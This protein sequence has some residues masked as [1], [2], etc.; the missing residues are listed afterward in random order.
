MSVSGEGSRQGRLL[1]ATRTQGFRRLRW[2]CS[3]VF[4]S[5]IGTEVTCDFWC[6]R[7]IIWFP[8]SL[9]LFVAVHGRA[10][11]VQIFLPILGC[12]WSKLHWITASPVGF[13][14]SALR[15]VLLNQWSEH[16]FRMSL[17]CCAGGTIREVRGEISSHVGA[18]MGIPSD[19]DDV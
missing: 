9:Q 14:T 19:V 7:A 15:L 4:C 2:L 17:C 8:V 3:T 5:P 18:S 6:S 13:K 10:L 1:I 11:Y 16:G 12:G